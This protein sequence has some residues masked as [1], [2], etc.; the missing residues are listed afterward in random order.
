[1]DEFTKRRVKAAGKMAVGAA[2]TAGGV[3]TATGHGT[4]GG[5]FKSHHMMAQAI[6]LGKHSVEQGVKT[7][8]SGLDDWRNA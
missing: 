3:M 4:L 7:F 5:F 8:R 1:M 6:R 2:R